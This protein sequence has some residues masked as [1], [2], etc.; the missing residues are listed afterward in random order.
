MSESIENVEVLIFLRSRTYS[1]FQG[2]IDEL[3][4]Y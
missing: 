3:L 1:Y 2:T 4:I